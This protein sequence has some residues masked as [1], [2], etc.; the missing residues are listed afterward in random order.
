MGKAVLVG[1]LLALWL[2]FPVLAAESTLLGSPE[3]WLLEGGAV[4]TLDENV[5]RFGNTG[6]EWP[7]ATRLFSAAVWLN[8]RDA[9]LN[10]DFTPQR[11]ANLVLLVGDGR[12]GRVPVILDRALC[13]AEGRSYAGD[14]PATAQA[15]RGE[16]LLSSLTTVSGEPLSALTD[17]AERLAVWGVKVTVLP[18]TD[19]KAMEVR[20]LTL[21]DKTGG[22]SEP[23]AETVPSAS[24]KT[25]SQGDQPPVSDASSA[26]RTTLPGTAGSR[27]TEAVPT[28]NTA[29]SG[30]ASG[31]SARF[32][33]EDDGPASDPSGD[34]VRAEEITG[35]GEAQ[36]GPEKTEDGALPRRA[37]GKTALWLG[38]GGIVLAAGAAWLLLFR[39]PPKN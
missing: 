11:K 5:W 6:A 27:R 9:R 8:I 4:L 29:V 16:I 34:A 13:E 22:T 24:K 19:G 26:G 18:G 2:L 21:S 10:Y 17:T 30:D 37:P 12:G 1:A 23:E 28:G 14:I 35:R 31:S 38:A 32:E 36:S 20:S 15:W 25:T 33:P 39:G 7:S 3:S